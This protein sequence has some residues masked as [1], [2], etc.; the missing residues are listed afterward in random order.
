[1]S[2]T[3]G[4]PS[5]AKTSTIIFCLSKNVWESLSLGFRVQN[6]DTTSNQAHLTYFCPAH[7]EISCPEFVLSIVLSFSAN[8]LCHY[9]ILCWVLPLPHLVCDW[10]SWLSRPLC[11][12]Q[13]IQTTLMI[14]PG[15]SPLFSNLDAIR[16][17]LV[18]PILR[19]VG[20][21]AVAYAGKFSCSSR[22]PNFHRRN[23]HS[24]LS[25]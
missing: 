3:R 6:L 17:K 19:T 22:S 11:G 21:V 8:S 10:G 5:S 4:R 2:Q 9:P 20:S 7:I 13:S 14:C 16:K 1:M 18:D 24:L 12:T 15:G 25:E 23:D